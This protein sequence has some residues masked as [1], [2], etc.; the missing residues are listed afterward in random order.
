SLRMSGLPDAKNR[1]DSSTTGDQEPVRPPESQPLIIERRGYGKRAFHSQYAWE[2]VVERVDK[3]MKTFQC[4][5]LPLMLGDTDP[6][7]VELTEFSFD[8][9]ATE[10]DRSL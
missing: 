2:G 1:G 8:D 7:K 6:A 9:L 3:R 4:R 5:I 10:S